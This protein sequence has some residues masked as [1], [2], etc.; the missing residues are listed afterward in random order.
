MVKLVVEKEGRKAP[1]IPNEEPS[2]LLNDEPSTILNEGLCSRCKELTTYNE[3]QRVGKG[4]SFEH[5]AFRQICESATGNTP[6][7]ICAFIK[8]V[9]IQKL[10]WH[11][12]FDRFR[13]VILNRAGTSVGFEGLSRGLS[14]TVKQADSQLPTISVYGIHFIANEGNITLPRWF[15]L[16]K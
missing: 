12:G 15:H 4:E 5:G 6:C 14:L 2:T 7:Q 11:P 13:Q 10:H 9:V 1:T 16:T 3:L 8:R